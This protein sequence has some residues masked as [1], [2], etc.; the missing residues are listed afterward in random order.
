MINKGY[1]L[2]ANVLKVGHHGGNTSTSQEFLDKFKPKYTVIS[3][4]KGND[5]GHPTAATMKRLHSNGIKVFRTDEN[6]TIVCT[7]DEKNIGF[8]CN[9]GDYSSGG[10]SSETSNGS[11]SVA[12]VVIATPSKNNQENINSKYEGDSATH[13]F[14]LISCRY[15]TKISSNH[16]VYFKTCD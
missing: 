4:I 10:G 3:V 2:S 14:H 11:V 5:Y 7:S 8:N 9:P 6:G 12:P 13:K 15:A 16:A 1:D